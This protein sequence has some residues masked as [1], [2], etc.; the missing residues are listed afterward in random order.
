MVANRRPLTEKRSDFGSLTWWQE[1]PWSLTLTQRFSS[2]LLRQK[3]IEKLTGQQQYVA[4]STDLLWLGGGEKSWQ[5]ALASAGMTL[6][7]GKSFL[8]LGTATALLRTNGRPV[9]IW[10]GQEK[11]P[12]G[13]LDWLCRHSLLL[14]ISC[15]SAQLADLELWQARATYETGSIIKLFDN[16]NPNLLE[17]CRALVLF[18]K[19]SGQLQQVYLKHGRTLPV[20][21]MLADLPRELIIKHSSYSQTIVY[22]RC[23]PRRLLPMQG[24]LL[25]CQNQPE[26]WQK[27]VKWQEQ[28]VFWGIEQWLADLELAGFKF[29][30]INSR[31]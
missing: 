9:L 22:H 24:E 3:L 6:I 13:F 28:G 7:T 30:M 10:L 11:L 20:F 1:C 17:Q 2:A 15:Q 26:L 4:L 25:L 29:D 21:S 18:D 23:Q 12:E 19:P 5:A 16:V 27:L 8:V 14:F 31:H